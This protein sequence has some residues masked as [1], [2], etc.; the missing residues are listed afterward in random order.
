MTIYR[1]DGWMVAWNATWREPSNWSDDR[2]PGA[3]EVGPFPDKS[4]WSSAYWSSAGCCNFRTNWKGLSQEQLMDELLRGFF[5]LVLSET[6]D[7][8][9]VHREF[10]KIEGYLT[11]RGRLG[12]GRGNGIYF[13][14]SRLDPYN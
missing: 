12:L 2:K 1:K 3:I 10:S 4:G 5:F 8:N 7:P 13:Q 11:Y 14:D 6:I 9:D